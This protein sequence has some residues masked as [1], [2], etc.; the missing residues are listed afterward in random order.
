[1]PQFSDKI[2][3]HCEDSHGNLFEQ[4]NLRDLLLAGQLARSAASISSSLPS[5]HRVARP[6][7]H[8][9]IPGIF[10]E[11]EPRLDGSPRHRDT[12]L[13]RIARQEHFSSGRTRRYVPGRV[14]SSSVRNA[15]HRQA[16]RVKWLDPHRSSSDSAISTVRQSHRALRSPWPR[17][18]SM[19]TRPRSAERSRGR[20]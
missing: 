19:C 3:P 6:G 14:R 16:L 17:C 4:R 18:L 2:L 12:R 15:C 13:F 20:T 9:S 8:P 1:M 10:P 11:A 5:A 7:Q